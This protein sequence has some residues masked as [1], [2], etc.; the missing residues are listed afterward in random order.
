MMETVD[1]YELTLRDITTSEFSSHLEFYNDYKEI[2]VKLLSNLKLFAFEEDAASEQE[3][4]ENFSEHPDRYVSPEIPFQKRKGKLTRAWYDIWLN[5][6][7]KPEDINYDIFFV[8]KFRHL[9]LLELDSFLNYQLE[10]Y[11]ESD[12]KQFV[13]FLKLTMRK[14]SKKLLQSEQ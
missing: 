14:H 9:D 2:A 5:Y 1:K 13:R 8:L 11:Y 10:N 12:S 6:Q 3:E 4:E 7:I